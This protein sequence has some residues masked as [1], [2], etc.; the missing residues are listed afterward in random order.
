MRWRDKYR[1]Q[2][3]E[4]VQANRDKHIEQIFQVRKAA[5]NHIRDSIAESSA[6]DAAKVYGIL[7]DKELLLR[8]E[9]TERTAVEIDGTIDLRAIATR[10]EQRL[11]LLE[12]LS[13]RRGIT[14]DMSALPADPGGVVDSGDA[15]DSDGQLFVYHQQSRRT[16]TV[17]PQQDAEETIRS[18]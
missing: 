13:R 16:A 7:T 1:D 9:P 17:M 14:G 12:Q 5:L 15:A 2:Y 18:N 8:G 3:E 6:L 10:T 11:Q 4:C